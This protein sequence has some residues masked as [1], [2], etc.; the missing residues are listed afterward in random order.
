MME[1]H[2][3]R[4]D[5]PDSAFALHVPEL[6]VPVG[7]PECWVGASGTGKTT[8]LHLVAGILSPQSGVV[9]VAGKDLTNLSVAQRREFRISQMGLIFQDFALL[10]Y[11]NVLENILLPY[12]LHPALHLHS[13]Q[14]ERAQQ[15]AGELGLGHLLERRPGKLSQGER[16]RV[17]V[18]R[19]LV[20]EPRLVLADEP[21]ANLDP[22]N[23]TRV[24]MALEGYARHAKA[25]LVV[26]SHDRDVIARFAQQ[27]NVERFCLGAGV[28]VPDAG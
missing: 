19:A 17:A 28:E 9:R 23:A 20:T 27:T 1:L 26:V 7:R 11:L 16:Q 22:A 13:A 10:S 24:W 4:F 8:L 6:V 15:L 5:Y 2:D 25:A 18:C 14:R 12:R 21:T 3:L